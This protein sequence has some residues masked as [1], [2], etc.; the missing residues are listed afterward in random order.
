MCTCLWLNSSRD[1]TWNVP[2]RL[3]CLNTWP[4]PDG[5]VMG[6]WGTLKELTLAGRSRLLQDGPMGYD[7]AWVLL[8]VSLPP[9]FPYG[10]GTACLP[11]PNVL[12]HAHYHVFLTRKLKSKY[13]PCPLGCLYREFCP[14]TDANKSCTVCHHHHHHLISTGRLPL[15]LSFAYAVL[16]LWS[17]GFF[18]SFSSAFWKSIL[19]C[20]PGWPKKKNHYEALASL[21]LTTHLY[22]LSPGLTGM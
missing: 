2:H 18:Q 11:F 1:W 15:T 21:E 8:K 22:F 20:S 7:L 6:G 3:R 19:L 9:L 5:T 14:S 16:S 4:P 17:K 10:D 12:P 13:T